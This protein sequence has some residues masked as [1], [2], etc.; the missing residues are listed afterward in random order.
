MTKLLFLLQKFKSLQVNKSVAIITIALVVVVLVII[1]LI[2]LNGRAFS[3]IGKVNTAVEDRVKTVSAF[4]EVAKPV[5]LPP[6]KIQV[7]EKV[8]DVEEISVEEGG[9]L[10]V[11]SSWQTA[12][13]YK[14]GAK[15]GEE[16]NVLV[17]G[18]YDTNTGAPGA[19]WG[20]KDLQV[21]DKVL[22]TD[23][24]GRVFEYSVITKSSIGIS[25]PERWQVFAS[26]KDK[27]LTLITCG[28][29]WDYA[30]HTYNKR[31]VITA[32]FVKMEKNW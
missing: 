25:D 17:D 32:V 11:P 4:K 20:L 2:I 13:W 18:H 9:F 10:G 3:P 19:F 6:I 21:G 23:K 28:G 22:L 31:L 27:V 29:V 8:L 30:S 1:S 14:E 12:G 26:G 15:P 7:K 16:G 5:Y 24:L